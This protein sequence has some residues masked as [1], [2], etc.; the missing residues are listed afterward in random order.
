VKEP[1]NDEAL[2]Q[3]MKL[4]AQQKEPFAAALRNYQTEMTKI[5]L[6][7]GELNDEA[8]RKM[9]KL[10][11]DCALRLKEFLSPEQMKWYLLC[12]GPFLYWE[13]KDHGRFT[14]RTPW[15]DE[16]LKASGTIPGSKV[17]EKF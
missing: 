17:D 3:S 1:L 14:S 12:R 5:N 9:T 2:T 7:G 8:L 15:I 4:Q 16:Y 10:N 13:S 6:G 11:V